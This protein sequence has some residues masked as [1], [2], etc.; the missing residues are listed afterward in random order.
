MAGGSGGNGERDFL[1]AFA[2]DEIEDANDCAMGGVF[3]TTDVDGDVGVDAKFLGEIF[4]E[5]R[6]IYL[7]F[8]DINVADFVDGNIDDVGLEIALGH[9]GRGQI[10]FDGLQFHHAQA[11]EHERGEQEE[12]DVD[13]R[14][15]LNARFSMREWRA[16]FHGE[17]VMRD[18]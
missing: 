6:E 17:N 15:D 7:L 12:H 9:R 2:A 4:V 11:R 16:D 13:E 5:V 8:L 3:V 10:H 18:A 1:D 14:N